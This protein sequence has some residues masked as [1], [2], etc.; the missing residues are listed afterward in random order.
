[1]GLYVNRIVV[2]KLM[3]VI[4]LGAESE[5]SLLGIFG[6]SSPAKAGSG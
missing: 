6:D 3:F 2:V 4:V 5:E 1:M